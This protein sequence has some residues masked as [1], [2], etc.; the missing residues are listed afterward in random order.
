MEL[1]TAL[2][3]GDAERAA[4]EAADLVYHLTVAL[5]SVGAS[6]EDVRAVLDRR[7]AKDD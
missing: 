5:H 7:A 3:D 4:E 6:L 2:V 1:V